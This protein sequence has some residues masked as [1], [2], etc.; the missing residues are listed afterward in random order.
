MQF[1]VQDLGRSAR[2]QGCSPEV[3]ISVW[4]TQR[5]LHPSARWPFCFSRPCFPSTSSQRP[6]SAA[7]RAAGSVCDYECCTNCDGSRQSGRLDSANV[8]CTHFLQLAPT[9]F[10]TSCRS[11]PAPNNGYFIVLEYLQKI[12]VRLDTA[13]NESFEVSRKFGGVRVKGG[14]SN[15]SR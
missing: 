2:T 13:G 1:L 5:L 9:P 14:M 15:A 6:S 12:G 7:G 11:R 3:D 4:L 8:V 10:S